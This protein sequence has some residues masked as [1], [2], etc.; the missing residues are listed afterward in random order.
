MNHRLL[1]AVFVS[2]LAASAS[3]GMRAQLLI[4]GLVRPVT[5]VQDPVDPT[6][7]YVVEQRSG[8]VGR[9]RVIQ[10]G[11]LLTT[12]FLSISP[13]STGGEQGLLGLAFAPDYA[14][15]RRFYVNYTDSTGATV[16]ARYLRSTSN[17]LVADATSG[18]TVM[19]FSQPFA[20]HNGGSMEFGPDGYLYIASGDGGDANDPGDRAQN[21]NT[22]LGKILRIDIDGDDFPGDS[23]RNYRI[24]SSNPFAT[25]GGL[26]EIWAY[27]LRNPWKITFD[28]PEFLGRGSMFIGDVG[29]DAREEISFGPFGAGGRN[30]GWRCMEGNL[31]TG[32]PGCTQSPFGVPPIFDYDRSFGA[33]ITGGYLYQGLKLGGA[34]FGRYVFADFISGRVFSVAIHYLPSGEA[35]ASDFQEHTAELETG[36]DLGLI[37]GF[38]RDADGELYVLSYSG[39]NGRIWRIEPDGV[40]WPTDRTLLQGSFG[41][42]SLRSVL[43]VD[44]NTQTLNLEQAAADRYTGAFLLGLQTD[45]PST[46]SLRLRIDVQSDRKA[47][48]KLEV[49]F[50]DWTTGQMRV[51]GSF[52]VTSRGSAIHVPSFPAAG[53]IRSDGRIEMRLLGTTVVPPGVDPGRPRVM[54][55]RVQLEIN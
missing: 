33:S 16:I 54:F 52:D 25:G 26:P 18:Q 20:N 11:V 48:T 53:V 44:R 29:Q 28:V 38:G 7:Q 8:N 46:S 9:I 40:V 34:M 2:M 3:A 36:G 51:L 41:L 31:H 37:S 5:F 22:L 30:Y 10:G 24:P 50:R 23:Q 6:V 43:V 27:G 17:P 4:S 45:R 47:P 42:G 49:A 12:P 39:T 13:V 15:S 32:L 35:T 21:L 55:D 1:I 19:Q 14:T